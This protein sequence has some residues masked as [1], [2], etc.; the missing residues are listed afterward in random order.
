M[1]KY[2]KIT[3]FGK[4]TEL[5]NFCTDE[6]L[7]NEYKTAWASQAVINATLNNCLEEIYYI[8]MYLLEPSE[9]NRHRL[10]NYDLRKDIF[11][12]KS[13][14]YKELNLNFWYLEY[15]TGKNYK[16]KINTFFKTYAKKI[17]GGKL[18]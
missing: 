13:K 15:M 11:G 8:K 3:L 6:R 4:Y 16:N 9:I 1:T 12:N 7:I 5:F 17:K 10:Y 14:L 2:E 18:K